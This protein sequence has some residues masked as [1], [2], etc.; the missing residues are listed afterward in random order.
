MEEERRCKCGCDR[1]L[2]RGILETTQNWRERKFFNRRC[3]AG[4]RE[5]RRKKK[6]QSWR[7]RVR[8]TT[9]GIPP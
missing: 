3:A 5:R 4:H 1:V 7:Q 2:V 9:S 6:K 8:V